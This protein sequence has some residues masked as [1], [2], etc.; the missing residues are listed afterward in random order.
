MIP[1]KILKGISVF[2][3]QNIDRF[4]NVKTKEGELNIDV[5]L[6]KE[7]V[8][9]VNNNLEEINKLINDPNISITKIY[10]NESYFKLKKIDPDLS[11]ICDLVLS[12][13]E[14]GKNRIK[15]IEVKKTNKNVIP[16]SSVNQIDE[17]KAVVFIKTAK[18]IEVEVG[19]YGQAIN[20]KVRFPDRSP[21]PEVSFK[22]LKESNQR[23]EGMESNEIIEDESEKEAKYY[24]FNNKTEKYLSKEWIKRLFAFKMTTWFD[25]A[26][27]L[28]SISLLSKY[29]K[30]TKEEKK[31]FI[32]K[33][34]D[35]VDE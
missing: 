4:K 18:I 7:I 16:G 2:L 23:N 12:F 32:K 19:Y 33:L 34:K 6:K 15:D 30:M 28:Y 25:K 9:I 5:H 10:T 22:E 29:D 27:S 14:N 26:V 11:K 35:N 24:I 31:I 21:R 3:K 17:Y 8:S 20:G 1:V 13:K